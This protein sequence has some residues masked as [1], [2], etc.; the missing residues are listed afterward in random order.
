MITFGQK[1]PVPDLAHA[2]RR[3]FFVRDNTNEVT[4][5]DLV[6]I[7]HALNPRA[8]DNVPM[9]YR[10]VLPAV[11]GELKKLFPIYAWT[12]SEMLARDEDENPKVDTKKEGDDTTY[13]FSKQAGR[14]GATDAQRAA[15]RLQRLKAIDNF[16]L[17]N[18]V[19]MEVLGISM[20]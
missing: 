6:R 2:L 9:T 10:G 5:M 13:I 3:S 15:R 1:F 12:E 7:L 16:L 8:L 4:L 18:F 11:W 17:A 14:K 20:M 19:A